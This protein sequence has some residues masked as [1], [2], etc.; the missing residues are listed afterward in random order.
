MFIYTYIY[1]YSVQIVWGRQAGILEI[2]F[3]TGV[4]WL[5][6][7][8]RAGGYVTRTYM[9]RHVSCKQTLMLTCFRVP[10]T[11]VPTSVIHGTE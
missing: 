5:S 6:F 8:R 2:E 10:M 4:R 11:N 1:E 3:G 9:K 7:G